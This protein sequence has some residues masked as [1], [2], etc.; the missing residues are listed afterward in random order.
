[1]I[2]SLYFGSSVTFRLICI[3]LYYELEY[4]SMLTSDIVEK[5]TAFPGLTFQHYT[6]DV[7]TGQLV[8]PV[9]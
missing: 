4:C 5:F 1:M 7:P 6:P 3:V 9:D 2:A 8:N